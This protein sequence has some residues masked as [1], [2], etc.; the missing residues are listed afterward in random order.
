[1]DTAVAVIAV[2]ATVAGCAII[3]PF[4]RAFAKRLEHRPP[5]VAVPD[6]AIGE[7]RQELD[8][9]QERLDFIE[10]VLVAQKDVGERLLP[11]KRDRSE[12]KI[13]TPS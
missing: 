3:V 13:Q 1:M 4:A 5:D 8:A 6:P 2:L 11:G 12:P 10:R 7:L 9:L